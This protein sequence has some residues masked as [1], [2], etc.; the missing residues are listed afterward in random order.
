[1]IILTTIFWFLLILT[2]IVFLHEM[3]HLL[4][5]RA[6]G[7]F[8][9]EFSIGFGKELCSYKCK[10]GTKWKISAIPL[11]G[12]VRFFG[13]ATV[14][15]SEDKNKL[16][17]MNTQERK[18]A[19][20][21]KP[22]W[23]KFFIVFAGPAANYLTALVI[24]A[25][26]FTVFGK[27]VITPEITKVIENSPAAE[28]GLV[29]GDLITHANGKEVNTMKDLY[30]FIVMNQQ[31]PIN[32][33]IENEGG[34][35]EEVVVTPK[36]EVID[37]GEGIT[38]KA[39]R[40]GIIANNVTFVKFNVLSATAEAAKE[41]YFM[42]AQILSFLGQMVT[43]ERS[44]TQIGGPIT[45][46]KYSNHSAQQGFYSVVIFIALISINIGLVNLLPIPIVD[47]GHLVIYAINMLTGRELPVQVTKF[48][49][50]LG[51]VFLILLT[52]FVVISDIIKLM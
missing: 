26:I 29:E 13:D 38:E 7:V 16:D 50:F 5:A 46:A 3:G 19:F 22:T 21:F 39:P 51:G 44:L 37:Y 12:Y 48:L 25:S 20:H 14:F 47:G 49:Y 40:I 33:T 45:F 27:S 30:T 18:R 6:C 42:T 17:S 35:A 34:V 41:C 2:I 31:K 52:G 15:S 32:F 43:G 24:F 4:A 10:R 23:Q 28:A 8:V 9:E 1:M 11:G 36:L